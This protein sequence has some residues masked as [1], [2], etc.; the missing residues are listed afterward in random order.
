MHRYAHFREPTRIIISGYPDLSGTLLKQRA[1]AKRRFLV[2]TK[3]ENVFPNRGKLKFD[4]LKE[5]VTV[6]LHAPCGLV[7]VSVP[8]L[9]GGAR[10]DPSQPVSF[11]SADSF[12]TGVDVRVRVPSDLLWPELHGRTSVIADFSYGGAF[13]C[14]VSAKE[15]GFEN[16]LSKLNMKAIDTATRNL[17]SAANN[18]SNMAY[19]FEHPEHADLSFL[20]SVIVVDDQLGEPLAGSQS[21]ESGLCFFADQQVDRSPT[22]SGVSARLVLA[23]A[24]GQLQLGES[25]TYHSLVSLHKHG[26]AAFVGTLVEDSSSQNVAPYPRVKTRVEGHASYTGASTF[27]VEAGDVLGDE[28]FLMSDFQHR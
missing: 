7:H 26:S 15:L 8:V 3:D 25:S 18:N 11:I 16:G 1:Q 23:Y 13:Y 22:G 9:D 12:V 20:Y 14:L 19:I 6:R 10:S 21:A 4:K 17:K 28:G 5:T 24:K 2:D 27:V